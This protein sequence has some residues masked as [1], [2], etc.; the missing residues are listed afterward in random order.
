M[1]TNDASSN[2]AEHREFLNTYYGISRWFYDLTRKYYLFGRDVLLAELGRESWDSLVEVGPGTGRNLLKLKA[3]R[4]L[5]KYG[6]IE[7]S[8]AM[9]EYAEK[10]L[11]DCALKHGFAEDAN[12]SE[13]VGCPPDR[14]LY[15]YCL[16][17][18]QDKR[19]ALDHA[20]AQISEHG[21]VVVVDFGDLSA[22]PAPFG[23]MLRGWLETFHVAPLD[24]SLLSE[25]T[26]DIT[27]GLGRYYVI[28]RISR[29]A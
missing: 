11:P 3:M 20:R 10:R 26:D 24:H 27:Y 21:E 22:I 4:P 6:G 12:F 9:L 25:Y 19:K 15:S 17:M 5:A 16:S 2:Q 28:S 29:D 23:P 1:S 14:V 13:L 18:V 7:A 8:D